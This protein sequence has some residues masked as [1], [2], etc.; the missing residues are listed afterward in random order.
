MIK[1]NPE[2]LKQIYDFLDTINES[3]ESRILTSTKFRFVKNYKTK[4]LNPSIK[5]ITHTVFK[6]VNES[7]MNPCRITLQIGILLSSKKDPDSYR[8]YFSSYNSSL[9]QSYMIEDNIGKAEKTLLQKLNKMNIYDNLHAYASTVNSDS[10]FLG[11][12]NLC[13]HINAVRLTK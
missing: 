1:I 10:V 5:T 8:H 3:I 9:V 11:I 6:A 13:V 7:K 2:R 4:T 12:T